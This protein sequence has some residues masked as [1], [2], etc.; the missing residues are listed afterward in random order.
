MGRKA[1]FGNQA[2][3]INMRNTRVSAYLLMAA[4]QLAID[5]E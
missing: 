1:Q 5:H 2:G 4:I 3:C